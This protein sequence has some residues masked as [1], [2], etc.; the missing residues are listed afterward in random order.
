[1]ILTL[2]LRSLLARPIRSA[3]LAGGFGLGVA[4]MAALLGI[5]GGD[6]R[7][8]ARAR[9]RR[10][11]RRRHRRR[12]PVGCECH[13]RALRRASAPVRSRRSVAVGGAHRLRAGA[14]PDRRDAERRRSGPAA[15]FRASSARSA[16][17]KRRRRRR[18]PTRRPIARGS[19]PIR[20][21]SCARWIGSIRSRRAGA[22]RV[23]G[24]VALL[25]RPRGVGRRFYLTFHRRSAPGIRPPAVGVRLQLERDGPHDVRS[26]RRRRSTTRRC[27]R[28][29]RTSTVGRNRVRLDRPGVPHRVDLPAGERTRSAHGDIAVRRHAGPRRCRLSR[30]V[31]PEAGCRATSFR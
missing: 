23:V 10:R 7:A 13:V 20:S 17:R 14:L 25:Q 30:F 29:R 24:R 11:R 5:G 15:A 18:G 12:R 19:R 27:S 26:R 9:A 16:I 31:A 3:V 4:V 21:R 22:R 28:P 8:G 2:A 1:M 6:P